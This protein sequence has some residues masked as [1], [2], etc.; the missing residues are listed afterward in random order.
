MGFL[1]TNSRFFGLGSHSLAIKKQTTALH[2]TAPAPISGNRVDSLGQAPIL[3]LGKDELTLVALFLSARDLCLFYIASGPL[4]GSLLLNSTVEARLTSPSGPQ[5]RHKFSSMPIWLLRHLP[6]LRSITFDS[7]FSTTRENIFLMLPRTVEHVDI[8]ATML[9]V[10]AVNFKRCLPNLTFLKLKVSSSSGI[11]WLATLPPSLTALSIHNLIAPA[12]CLDYLAGRIESHELASIEANRPDFKRARAK[13]EEDSVPGG[14]ERESSPSAQTPNE[15]A[16]SASQTPLSRLPL[17]NLI[18]LDFILIIPKKVPPLSSLP[19]NL[20][21]FGWTNTEEDLSSLLRSLSQSTAS[22]S[23]S[24]SFSSSASSLSASS[25]PHS[26]SS[27]ATRT[28]AVSQQISTDP[29]LHHHPASSLRSL[30]LLS[31]FEYHYVAPPDYSPMC[32]LERMSVPGVSY[33]QLDNY[34]IKSLIELNINETPLNFS[35]TESPHFFQLL[36]RAGARLRTLKLGMIS[37]SHD[38][39][40]T[41]ET[42]KQ[43]IVPS[44]LTTVTSLNIAVCPPLFVCT[45]PSGLKRLE[46]GSKMLLSSIWDETLLTTLPQELIELVVPGIGIELGNIPLLPRSLRLLEFEPV[47]E[48]KIGTKKLCPDMRING[49]PYDSI[50]GETNLVFGLPPNLTQLSLHGDMIF[51]SRLGLFLPRSLTK[52]KSTGMIDVQDT[53]EVVLP[54]MSEEEPQNAHVRRAILFFPPGCSSAIEL[55]CSKAIVLASVNYTT[56][57]TLERPS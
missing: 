29:T 51:E 42:L 57:E 43:G 25:H 22:A 46:L 56:M 17:P 40:P 14:D 41:T 27:L 1:I 31:V 53:T 48:E 19:P 37:L 34:F 4:I 36:H 12:S 15:I 16:P 13:I 8:S 2:W 35:K 20:T 55:G 11:N 28:L 5:W 45:F 52:I 44:V 50:T 32:L 6:A 47:N 38:D 30:R 21:H 3:R 49:L 18:A 54:D 33:P 24:L 23:P 26:H 9:C 7:V 39:Q 10:F